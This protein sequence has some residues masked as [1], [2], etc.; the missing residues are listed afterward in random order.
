M[1]TAK[2]LAF[3]CGETLVLENILAIALPLL[4]DRMKPAHTPA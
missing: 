4:L 2:L 1:L 3:C